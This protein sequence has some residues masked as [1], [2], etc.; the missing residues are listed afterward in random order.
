MRRAEGQG[1]IPWEISIFK[2]KSEDWGPT[3]KTE[4]EGSEWEEEQPG[5]SGHGSQRVSGFQVGLSHGVRCSRER[6]RSGLESDLGGGSQ[7]AASGGRERPFRA[8]AVVR[9]SA[10]DQRVTGVR[11]QRAR[12][13][14]CRLIFRE[15]FG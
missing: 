3:R 5:Q 8:V 10:V 6:M 12:S 1:H 13:G 15:V 14:G 2:R 4:A 7:V 11:N 9:W